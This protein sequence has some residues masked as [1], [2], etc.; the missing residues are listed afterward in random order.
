VGVADRTAYRTKS[1]GDPYGV[2]PIASGLGDFI[3]VD[4]DEGFNSP[5]PTTKIILDKWASLCY[6]YIKIER[7]K[8][9]Q[10]G[11]K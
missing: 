11:N 6:T 5:P 4:A 7:I 1:I 10:G 2:P 8:I 9:Q 3:G